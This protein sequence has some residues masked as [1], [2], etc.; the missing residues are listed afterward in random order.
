MTLVLGK[1]R[2]EAVSAGVKRVRPAEAKEPHM[3]QAEVI[4]GTTCKK[5][6]CNRLIGTEPFVKV[7]DRLYHL[8]CSRDF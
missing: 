7:N 8:A 6:N 2:L 5:V 3:K 4:A 1:L